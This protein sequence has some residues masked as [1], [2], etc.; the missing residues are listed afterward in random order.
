MGLLL[1]NQTGQPLR[2]LDAVATLPAYQACLTMHADLGVVRRWQ[3]G[4]MELRI[5]A[6]NPPRGTAWLAAE[7]TALSTIQSDALYDRVLWS[8][9]PRLSAHRALIRARGDWLVQA[10]FSPHGPQRSLEGAP[11]TRTA[12]TQDATASDA[13]V[14]LFRFTVR[15][16]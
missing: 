4:D 8:R 11:P 12:A 14:A 3:V 10:Q 5:G 6:A 1:I 15:A 2:S 13:D 16:R 7:L 9:D